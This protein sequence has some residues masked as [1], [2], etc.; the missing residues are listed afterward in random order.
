[1][2]NLGCQKSPKGF[3]LVE[4]LVVIAII[5]ML[6]A[7]LL[8]AVQAA[9]EAA[10]RMQC[11]NNL[12]QLGI[13]LHNHHDTFN[14]FPGTT[15]QVPIRNLR[16]GNDGGFLD[17]GFRR[18][19]GLVML[20]PYIE[21]T[22]L[23]EREASRVIPEGQSGGNNTTA[24]DL[25]PWQGFPWDG[26]WYGQPNAWSTLVAAFACP[27]DPNSSM[28]RERNLAGTNYRLCRGDRPV[29]WDQREESRGLFGPQTLHLRNFASVQDGTSNTI[30]FSEAVIGE[31]GSALI[32]GGI[33][34]TDYDF[35]G[36]AENPD[37]SQFFACVSPGNPRQIDPDRVSR[38]GNGGHHGGSGSRW[39]DGYDLYT[40]FYTY[41]PPN[42]IS[43]RLPRYDEIWIVVAASSHHPGGVNVCKVDGSVRF[44]TDSVDTGGLRAGT[45]IGG[46]FGQGAS[47]FGV[48]GALGTIAKGE[49]ASL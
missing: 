38:D 24:G 7:L 26:D 11:T 19:S 37:A 32:K 28:L 25:V 35:N 42:G 43:A 23:F 3:T 5:G 20:L 40:I 6:V 27:S 9:R 34:R 21:Q 48:W 10:R 12:K 30:A 33:C 18:H 14:N 4:L 29:A 13:A 22:A 45:R 46:G 8:P 15:N 16:P 31:Q 44:V 41:M 47:P 17:H 2:G 1:G 36:Q 39:G 49:T